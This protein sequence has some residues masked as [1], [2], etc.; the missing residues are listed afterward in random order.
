MRL[1]ELIN[2]VLYSDQVKI[3]KCF[4]TTASS[5]SSIKNYVLETF[6]LPED[7]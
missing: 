2:P 4:S 6:N 5:L 7:V 3:E 1:M